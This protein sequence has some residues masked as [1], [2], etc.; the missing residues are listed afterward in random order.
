MQQSHLPLIFS[1]M[2]TIGSSNLH[3]DYESLMCSTRGG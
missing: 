2:Q 3:A 1:V